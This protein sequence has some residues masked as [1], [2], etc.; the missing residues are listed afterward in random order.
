M[1]PSAT[2]AKGV[3]TPTWRQDGENTFQVLF[4]VTSPRSESI[5]RERV[6][7]R[8]DKRLEIIIDEMDLFQ[9]EF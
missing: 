9:A 2:E 4:D 5:G 1:L 6:W 3:N 8:R 7:P